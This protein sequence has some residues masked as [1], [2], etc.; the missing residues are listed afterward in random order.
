MCNGHTLSFSGQRSIPARSISAKAAS[1]VKVIHDSG[2]EKALKKLELYE[3]LVRGGLEVRHLRA[4]IDP[5]GIWGGLYR[6]NS[7]VKL[8]C[9]SMVR[10]VEAAERVF[11]SRVTELKI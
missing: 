11:V 6:E 9:D 1:I 2:L 10:L 7:E 8:V 4:L 5:L 3:I